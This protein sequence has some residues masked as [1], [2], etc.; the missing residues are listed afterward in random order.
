MGDRLGHGRRSRVAVLMTVLALASLAGCE[1]EATPTAPLDPPPPLPELPMPGTVSSPAGEYGW[2]GPAGTG[3][4]MH[5]VVRDGQGGWRQATAMGFEAGPDCRARISTQAPQEQ[6]RVAG[7]A[8]ILVESYEEAAPNGWSGRS[9]VTHAYALAVGDRTLCLYL[10]WDSQTTTDEESAAMTR[11]LET[12]RA[13]PE[14]GGGVRIVFTLDE[15]W[16]TG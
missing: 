2:G 5:K 14:W 4:G 15:G 8:G 11:I 1:A 9:D 13:E 7:L 6:V 3:G 16:D 10:M 12:I